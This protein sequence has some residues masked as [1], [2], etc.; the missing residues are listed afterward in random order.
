MQI[1]N[2]YFVSLL[3][4]LESNFITHLRYECVRVGEGLRTINRI[5][6]IIN[7]FDLGKKML[8]HVKR[9]EFRETCDLLLGSSY[10][11]VFIFLLVFG[12]FRQGNTGPFCSNAIPTARTSF[13]RLCVLLLFTFGIK[14]HRHSTIFAEIALDH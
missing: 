2:I 8:S 11:F 9:L 1:V 12:S 3:L 13:L 14:F 10:F 6:L 5:G 4:L 7:G